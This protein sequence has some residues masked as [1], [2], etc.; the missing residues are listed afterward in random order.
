MLRRGK[1]TEAQ[2]FAA[3]FN[4]DPEIVYKEQIKG[5]ISKLNVWQSETKGMQETFEEFIDYL[6]KIK[7]YNNI[8]N[9]QYFLNN[10]ITNMKIIF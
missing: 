3:T 8:N 6:N 1:Y 5:L 7:V 10:L 9:N 4:L 2:N